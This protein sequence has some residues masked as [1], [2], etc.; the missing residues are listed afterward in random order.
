ML[1]SGDLFSRGTPATLSMDRRQQ[2]SEL[3][4]EVVREAVRPLVWTCAAGSAA[5]LRLC[6][7]P[8]APLARPVHD[9]HPIILLI[10]IH[11]DP[12]PEPTLNLSKLLQTFFLPDLFPPTL[13]VSQDREN[14]RQRR[15]PRGR[16]APHLL[17]AGWRGVHRDGQHR[18]GDE[19]Q[20]Q[21]QRPYEAR[22]AAGTA[23]VGPGGAPWR[24]DGGRSWWW[25]WR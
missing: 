12:G 23:V 14:Q 15:D 16:S 10:Y 24:E 19:P 1:E 8:P 4:R 5:C 3:V 6:S 2:R 7:P 22:P 25:W 17:R 13:V 18:R 21:D 11:S 9:R 20:D